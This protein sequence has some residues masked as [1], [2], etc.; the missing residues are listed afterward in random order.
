MDAGTKI[1]ET[2]PNNCKLQKAVR[3]MQFTVSVAQ[4]LLIERIGANRF[5]CENASQQSVTESN[6]GKVDRNESNKKKRRTKLKEP[7]MSNV[8]LINNVPNT[9]QSYSSSNSLPMDVGSTLQP[10]S[11]KSKIAK[12]ETSNSSTQ[13]RRRTK[14]ENQALSNLKSVNRVLTRSAIR[15]TIET[16]KP[17]ELRIKTRS[18]SAKNMANA[19][20]ICT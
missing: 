17:A 15:Q 8:E 13:H 10:T 16:D 3:E 6:A 9:S 7:V 2:H 11:I 12:V 19:K 20:R 14:F 5:E 1:A 4:R 18:Q